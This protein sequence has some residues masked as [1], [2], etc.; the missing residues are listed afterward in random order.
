MKDLYRVIIVDD[1]PLMRQALKMI[2]E[3]EP[4]FEVVAEA[5]N[6]EEA[7]SQVEE[8]I[9]D[10]VIMDLLMPLMNGCDAIRVILAA[11]PE[12][13][14]LALSS[15]GE[16]ARILDAIQ[17]GAGGF[18]SKEAQAR[19]L[20]SAIRKVAQGEFYLN[21]QLNQELLKTLTPHIAESLPKKVSQRE[22]TLTIREKEILA[23]MADGLSNRSIAERLVLSE[24]TVR[25]HSYHIIN[26]LGLEDRNQAVVY[27]LKHALILKG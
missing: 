21:S 14:I 22:E 5:T 20:L 2:L 12:I 15:I 10:L 6:G 19:E 3:D 17:A 11:H 4:D 7:I 23:L 25:S 13:H 18:I 9:P 24:A 16:N 27:A 1:H 26:K 8:Y